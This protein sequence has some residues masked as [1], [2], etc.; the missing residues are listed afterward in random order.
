MKRYRYK[1]SYR[2][3]KKKSIFRSR[4]F[5]LG[6]LFLIILGTIFYFIVFFSAFQIK[7][8]K[9][10]GN[11]KIATEDL[12]NII[13][14]QIDKK[15]F[16]FN[17]KSIF[18][19]DLKEINKIILKSFPQ[20]ARINLDRDFPDVLTVQIEERKPVAIFS[21]EENYFYIDKEGIIFEIITDNFS[22]IFN[23]KNLSS[24]ARLELGERVIGEEKLNQI[25][26]IETKFKND[27]KIPL[28]EIL[29]MSESR[30]NVK[31]S[32]GW[33]VY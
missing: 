2:V 16:F 28:A 4:F 1:K 22:Q 24:T 26:K 10:S 19:T 21:Q 18:L 12:K 17:S 3:R 11:E 30:L 31:T 5:W 7:E 14:R 33:E 23:I 29:I 9:V 8:I 6:L 13:S 27:F 32:E 25:L 15:I 20:I